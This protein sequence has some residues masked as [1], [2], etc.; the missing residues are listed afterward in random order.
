M[1]SQ[2]TKMA[3]QTEHANQ[4]LVLCCLHMYYYYYYYYYCNNNIDNQPMMY[5]K[6]HQSSVNSIFTCHIHM[7]MEL[8]EQT[9]HVPLAFLSAFDQGF[10]TS[11]LCGNFLDSAKVRKSTLSKEKIITYCHLKHDENSSWEEK[12]YNK[13][14]T[15]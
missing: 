8:Y 15:Y 10:F 2:M 7:Q 6:I 11:M 12:G 5:V 1:V 4:I 3:Y 13:F 14:A 9:Y